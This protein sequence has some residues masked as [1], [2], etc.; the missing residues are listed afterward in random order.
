MCEAP[1]H[2]GVRLRGEQDGRKKNVDSRYTSTE[3]E[4]KDIKIETEQ[5][6]KGV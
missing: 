2:R 5:E 4:Q 1:H 6:G 3:T